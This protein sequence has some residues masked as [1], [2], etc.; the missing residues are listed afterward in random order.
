[1]H[2]SPNPKAVAAI[3]ASD[4]VIYSIGS[5]YTSLAPSLILMGI[6]T[7]IANGPR[8]KIL[9]LNGSLDRETGG[10]EGIDFVKAVVGCCD[11]SSSSSTLNHSPAAATTVVVNDDGTKPKNSNKDDDMK[12]RVKQYITHLIYIDHP[13]APYVDRE[14]LSAWGIEGVRLYG[15]KGEDGK[16]RYDEKA[17][18]QALGAILGRRDG[19]ERSRRNTLEVG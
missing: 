18:G 4:A 13:T 9:I 8:F 6:G 14:M 15:R 11:A 3:Q 19:K 5:L 12:I 7:A 1:M 10:F 17:F 16:M 2:P